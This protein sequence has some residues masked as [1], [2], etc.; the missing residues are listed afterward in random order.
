MIKSR[1]NLGP[2]KKCETYTSYSNYLDLIK[3]KVAR[4]QAI[5]DQ[6]KEI[7]D[8]QSRFDD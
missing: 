1:K 6:L 2:K 8:D 7:A 5:I 4:I 3:K